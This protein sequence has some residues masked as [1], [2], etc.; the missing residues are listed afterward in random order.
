[1]TNLVKVYRKGGKKDFRIEKRNGMFF[2]FEGA[3]CLREYLTTVEEAEHQINLI[4][5]NRKKSGMES[6]P[7]AISNGESYEKPIKFVAPS[8]KEKLCGSC[9]KPFLDDSPTYTKK[10]CGDKCSK[11]ARDKTRMKAT[12]KYS[13]KKTAQKKLLAEITALSSNF[14]ILL[15]KSKNEKFYWQMQGESYSVQYFRKSRGKR[16]VDGSLVHTFE[17]FGNPFLLTK[18]EFLDFIYNTKLVVATN[19]EEESR[20]GFKK[21]ILDAYKEIVEESKQEVTNAE[22]VFDGLQDANVH[23]ENSSDPLLK[24]EPKMR[25]YN[26]EDSPNTEQEDDF[27]FIAEEEKRIKSKVEFFVHIVVDCI[28]QLTQ[29]KHEG[30]NDFIF[31]LSNILPYSFA[32]VYQM[33]SICSHG[34]YRIDNLRKEMVSLYFEKKIIPTDFHIEEAV[35]QQRVLFSR[36][37][38]YYTENRSD[39]SDT[40]GLANQ[41]ALIIQNQ[42]IISQ[43]LNNLSE[44]VVNISNDIEKKSEIISNAIRQSVSLTSLCNDSFER[45][46]E[47]YEII[48]KMRVSIK[49]LQAKVSELPQKKRKWFF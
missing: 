17:K 25:D 41:V 18:Q 13:Q 9:E 11:I 36:R 10:Y 28:I 34:D 20:E 22:S 5:L 29:H 38:T 3:K 2:V 39:K 32:E 7:V 35:R 44:C 23:V 30:T 43:V 6:V 47:L 42:E 8:P 33:V 48:E 4:V 49:D 31:N 24:E 45:E 27:G 26:F 46:K 15:S 14:G 19:E 1:M 37:R 12:K 21:G 40:S 16:S